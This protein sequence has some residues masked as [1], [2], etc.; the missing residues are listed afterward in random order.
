MMLRRPFC[1]STL[2]KNTLSKRRLGRRDGTQLIRA[3]SFN[4]EAKGIRSVKQ[5]EV[6]EKALAMPLKYPADPRGPYRFVNR[7]YFIVT[8]RSDAETLERLMVGPLELKESL[9]RFEFMRM[10]HGS[11]FGDYCEA[12]QLI[13]VSGQGEQGI[14]SKPCT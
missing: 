6:M 4:S 1:N 8:Y 13:P 11:G 12:G 5:R 14:I 2:L 3:N 9:V 10:P 7:E